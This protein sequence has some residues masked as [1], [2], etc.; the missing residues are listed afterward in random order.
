MPHP[1]RQC[2]AKLQRRFRIC[3][4][5]LGLLQYDADVS[6]RIGKNNGNM[7]NGRGYAPDPLGDKRTAFIISLFAGGYKVLSIRAQD[8]RMNVFLN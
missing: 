5:D 3:D 1:V 8:K 4:S 7:R 6:F 2:D